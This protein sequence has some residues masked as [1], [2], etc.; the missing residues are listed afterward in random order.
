MQSGAYYHYTLFRTA[1][2]AI[3]LGWSQNGVTRLQLPERDAAATERRFL[4]KMPEALKIEPPQHIAHLVASIRAYAS[5]ETVDF[6]S[7]PVDL[8]EV[9][10]FRRNIYAAARKLAYG[11]TS[12]YGQLAALSGHAGLARETGQALGANPVAIIIPCHRILAAGG[13]I[14]GFSAHGGSFA[15]ERLLAMEGVRVGPPPTAQ[16]SFGF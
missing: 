7:A 10:P 8:A 16:Q 11:E 2:G 1:I 15:K 9:E 3:A 14:G 6:S 5:G 12:T 13:K 4:A